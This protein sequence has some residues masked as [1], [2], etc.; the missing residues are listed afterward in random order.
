MKAYVITLNDAYFEK[1]KKYLQN[2]GLTV[3]RVQGHTITDEDRKKYGIRP[4]IPTA[5]TLAHRKV[6]RLIA[7]QEDEY[8]LVIENDAFP[9]ASHKDEFDTTL[10]RELQ[11]IGRFDLLL[12]HADY[13]CNTNTDNYDLFCGSFAAYIISKE[14][15][16]KV[17]KL[18][19]ITGYPD[20]DSTVHNILGSIVKKKTTANL[21]HT[22]ENRKSTPQ[23]VSLIYY[24]FSEFIHLFVTRG[25][26]LGCNIITYPMATIFNYS[27][28]WVVFTCLLINFAILATFFSIK[29]C[30]R[31]RLILLC[32][33]LMIINFPIIPHECKPPI[34]PD[35][36][37]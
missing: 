13:A 28:S 29:T 5:I 12:L 21:F 30:T 17:L 36:E 33:F 34:V 22:D 4:I 18:P 24:L 1:Q 2:I 25:E 8:V 31:R 37:T 7:Q 10:A 23:Y 9:I 14:G 26:K 3:I 35:Y 11:K 15:A 19:I 32:I 6:Y 27:M 20:V 16:R